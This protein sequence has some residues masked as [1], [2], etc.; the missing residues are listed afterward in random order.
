MTHTSKIGKRESNMCHRQADEMARMVVCAK[1]HTYAFKIM[2]HHKA[3]FTAADQRVRNY[4]V[5]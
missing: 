4:K 1:K 2:Q 3:V 5:V